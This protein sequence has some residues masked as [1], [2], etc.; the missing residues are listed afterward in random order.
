MLGISRQNYYRRKWSKSK[1]QDI[2]LR[3]V[4]LVSSI[5]Q[6]MPRIGM[7]K[8]YHLL[9]APLQELKVG[10]DRFLS[11]LK[12]NHLTI[13]PYRNYRTTTNSYHRFHKHKN[14]IE[15]L[16]IVRPE[17]VWVSDITYIGNRNRKTYLALVTDAYSKKIVGFDLSNSLSAEGSIRALSMA[18][19][20]RM[21]KEPLIHHSDR[22]IQ[23]CCDEYQQVLSK[24][25]INT[26]MTES[27]DPYANAVAERV[28][29]IF[30]DEF[31]LERYN[32]NCGTM[33]AIVKDAIRIYNRERPHYSC[34]MNTPE[35]MH[36]QSN[37]II[38]TYNS[39][40]KKN[41]SLVGTGAPAPCH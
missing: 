17:Q 7:R 4:E 3:V 29:G 34:Y 6:R 18:I 27:Y 21:Y 39:L 36:K 9:H 15:N 26:S 33:K 13:K 12:A 40:K 14:L 32:V 28:N 10:R 23:Y 38:R 5:R 16:S 1:R 20:Q 22:G 37:V 25:K 19:K 24:N 8:M 11:I 35:W 31:S 30:K 2:A 41:S